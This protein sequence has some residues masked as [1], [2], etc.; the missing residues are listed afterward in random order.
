MTSSIVSIGLANPGEPIEQSTIAGFM[1]KAHQLDEVESR[2]LSF[3]YRKSG[4][5]SRYSVLDDF[6]KSDSSEFTFFPKSKNFEPFPG[7]KA[8]MD[9]FSKTAVDLCEAAARRCLSKPK[10]ETSEVTH[11]ILVSCTG[12]MAPGV[13]LQLMERLGL[14]DSVERYCVHFMGCYAAFTGLK[15]AD[16][17]LLAEPESRVLL[18]SVELCTLHFQKEYT[19]DNVLANSLFGDGAAAALVMNSDQGMRLQGYQSNV[20]REGESDMAWGIG[21][22]GFEMRLSKYIPSLLDKGIQQLLEKFENRYHLS[23][24]K[25]FAIHPGGK[26][27]LEKVKEA[28]QL[29]DSANEHALA[30]LSEFGNMSSSTILFVLHRMMNDIKIQGK[31]LAMGFGPGLTLET[32][33]LDK[34]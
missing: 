8:R 5:N 13:E 18:V 27:I 33:L 21:D 15:L 16:K 11:L 34:R 17:I 19:E 9:V 22:F 24:L 14:D 23:S 32:L 2:K 29:P 4:I 3:L 31:I 30:V 12:M 20:I 1:Q 25:H 10:I 6:E 26:Q 7:T 28:F